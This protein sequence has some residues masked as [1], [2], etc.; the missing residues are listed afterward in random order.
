M[1]FY[2]F[3]Y[4]KIKNDKEENVF[5]ATDSGANIHDHEG[6]RGDG[7]AVDGDVVSE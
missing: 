6:R 5:F 4:I 3:K 2:C 1:L 7:A